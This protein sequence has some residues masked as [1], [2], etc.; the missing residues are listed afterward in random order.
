MMKSAVRLSVIS[1]VLLIGHAVLLSL[2]TP[3]S[4]N[5]W[6]ASS[7]ITFLFCFMSAI[8]MLQI[9]RATIFALLGLVIGWLDPS[10]L[11]RV[12]AGGGFGGEGSG[13]MRYGKTAIGS[14][15]DDRIGSGA[16]MSSMLLTQPIHDH[17][18][19]SAW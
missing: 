19:R 8:E 13:E 14:C 6:I 3:L 9:R 17:R 18:E 15:H 2:R 4:T 12:A 16:E 5:M 7:I 11:I 1:A 10:Y